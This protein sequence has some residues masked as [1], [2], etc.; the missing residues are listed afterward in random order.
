[1]KRPLKT[2]PYTQQPLFIYC[3]LAPLDV[4][5]IEIGCEKNVYIDINIHHYCFV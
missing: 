3:T 4:F 2:I 5:P 1:M